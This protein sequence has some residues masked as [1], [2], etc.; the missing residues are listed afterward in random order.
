MKYLSLQL[1]IVFVFT[2]CGPAFLPQPT[3]RS[4][5]IEDVIGTW[6][7]RAF[8]S[9]AQN[10]PA[11]YYTLTIRFDPDGTYMQEIRWDDRS[12][13]VTHGGQW[14]LAGA[15]VRLT[16]LMVTDFD[17]DRGVGIWESTL[18]EWWMIDGPEEKLIL[19]GGLQRDPD[20]F[21][22]FKRR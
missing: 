2:G 1:L 15:Y 17:F 16:D 3:S 13:H 4:V 22:R 5:K 19:F 9:M 10:I 20:S 8:R 6:E 18:E 21:D 12:D 11:S 14:E 7:Q